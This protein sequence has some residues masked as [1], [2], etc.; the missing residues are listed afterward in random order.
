MTYL[1]ASCLHI[2]ILGYG[3]ERAGSKANGLGYAFEK[4]DG[5]RTGTTKPPEQK[6]VTY[7]VRWH[8]IRRT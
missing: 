2:N 6:E 3:L 1:V 8:H 5:R 7:D 4:F